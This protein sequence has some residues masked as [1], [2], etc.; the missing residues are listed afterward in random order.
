MTTT[1]EA[2]R[3]Y[4]PAWEKRSVVGPHGERL[5]SLIFRDFPNGLRASFAVETYTTLDDGPP[6]EQPGTYKR[7]VISRIAND[8]YPTWDE[9]R[10]LVR[11]CGFF[12]RSRDVF[13]LLPPDEHYV[14]IRETAF[15]WWQKVQE[16]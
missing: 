8:H 14:N 13:M 4:P 12:D 3:L 2:P 9:M 6:M 11:T 16:R 5:G 15:H 7:L 1:A 10:D